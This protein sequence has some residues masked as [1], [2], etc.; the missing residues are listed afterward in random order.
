MSGAGQKHEGRKEAATKDKFD[1]KK[2]KPHQEVS[3]SGE[4]K[5][6]G[7]SFTAADVSSAC[8]WGVPTGAPGQSFL[9][10]RAWPDVPSGAATGFF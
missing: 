2:K 4:A 9:V 3:L 7:D 6:K 10:G 1:K 5:G 8:A